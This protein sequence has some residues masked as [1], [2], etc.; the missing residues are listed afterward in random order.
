MQ[1][2][3]LDKKSNQPS[4]K[5][6]AIH[7][8]TEK[9]W[10]KEKVRYTLKSMQKQVKIQTEQVKFLGENNSNV[11]FYRNQAYQNT[12]YSTTDS[13]EEKMKRSST[14]LVAG[15]IQSPS[16]NSPDI[17]VITRICG[18]IMF[19]TCLL[20]LSITPVLVYHMMRPDSPFIYYRPGC[21]RTN[22]HTQ[23]LKVN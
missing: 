21:P 10:R 8:R 7:R 3:Q 14:N 15:P 16:K 4:S 19:V 13:G 1:E 12:P 9:Q 22:N 11:H 5:S 20:A 17:L 18:G 2:G 23:I 6:L